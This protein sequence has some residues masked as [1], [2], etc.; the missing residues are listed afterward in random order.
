[1][2]CVVYKSRK[3]GQTYLYLAEKK[4]FSV[5]PA[6]LVEMLGA[7][8]WVMDLELNPQRRLARANPEEVRKGLRTQGYYLQMPPGPDEI[9]LQK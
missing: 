3:R 5:L 9:M 1:M 8:E 6:A 7:L 4:D 2:K